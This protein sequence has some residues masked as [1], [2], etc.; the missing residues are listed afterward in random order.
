MRVLPFRGSELQ[1][2]HRR[3]IQEGALA[4]EVSM[5]RLTHRTAPG[6]TYFVTTKTWQSRTIFQVTEN[7]ETLI[8]CI[9]RHRDKGTYLLHEF[10]VMPNHLHLI[11]TPSEQTTLEK[12][13]QMVKG[14]S[15]HDI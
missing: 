6:F 9:V 5:S 11:L 2:R 13:M 1:L 15:S 7:A 4:P 14:G 8:E 3:Q 12:A 10:V